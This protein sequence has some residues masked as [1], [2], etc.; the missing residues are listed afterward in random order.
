MSKPKV[1]DNNIEK[2]RKQILHMTELYVI[3]QIRLPERKE[4]FEALRG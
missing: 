4:C 3:H 2:T 1:A